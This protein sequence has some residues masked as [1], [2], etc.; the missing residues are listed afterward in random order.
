MA[1]QNNCK[2]NNRTGFNPG[3]NPKD[4]AQENRKNYH[5]A[6]DQLKKGKGKGNS[7]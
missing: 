2:Y 7:K 1:G 6:V 4:Q 5:K 3:S